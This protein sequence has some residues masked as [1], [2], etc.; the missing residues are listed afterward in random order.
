ALGAT[1]GGGALKLEAT[2]LRQLPIPIFSGSDKESL[3]NLVRETLDSECTVSEFRHHRVK[4]DRVV[5]SALAKRR[6]SVDET[7][8]T[9][10]KLAGIIRSLRAKRRRHHHNITLDEE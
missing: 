7:N 1:L 3:R 6:V 5:V 10:E 2:H 8:A 4:I 9:V